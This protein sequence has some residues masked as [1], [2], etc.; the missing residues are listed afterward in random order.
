MNPEAPKGILPMLYPGDTDF[1]GGREYIV[2][3]NF[4][5]IIELAEYAMLRKGRPEIVE[6][7]K[8][9]VYGIFEAMRS[10]DCLLYTSRCV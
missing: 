10:Y 2:N 8:P 3:W 7:L 5:L 4:W 6:G 1:I 9:S